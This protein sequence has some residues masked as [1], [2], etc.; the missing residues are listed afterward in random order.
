VGVNGLHASIG[1]AP[2]ERTEVAVLSNTS[3]GAFGTDDIGFHRLD[4]NRP[5]AP[6]RDEMPAGSGRLAELVGRYA[7]PDGWHLEIIGEGDRIMLQGSAAKPARLF[8]E[9]PDA[10][11]LKTVDVRFTVVRGSSG[12][13]A[14]LSMEQ[15]ETRTPLERVTAH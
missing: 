6:M 1:Y 15:R 7:A 2:A 11:F 5:L 9:G 3:A 10:W 12:Q 4:E 14:R 8:A 13:V